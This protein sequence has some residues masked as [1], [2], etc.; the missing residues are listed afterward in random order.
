MV[1]AALTQ[2]KQ[3]VP[4]PRCWAFYVVG[5]IWQNSFETTHDP[6]RP[7]DHPPDACQS[8]LEFVKPHDA[9]LPEKRRALH[10]QKVIGSNHPPMRRSLPKVLHF[11]LQNIKPRKSQHSQHSSCTF[12]RNQALNLNFMSVIYRNFQEHGEDSDKNSTQYRLWKLCHTKNY[13][14]GLGE[15]RGTPQSPFHYRNAACQD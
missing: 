4:V 1:L 13:F 8:L 3:P 11:I 5:H 2:D 15:R 12:W 10:R 14:C 9:A 7:W 6:D